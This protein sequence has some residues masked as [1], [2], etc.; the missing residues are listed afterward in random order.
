MHV[1]NPE[2]GKT[3]QTGAFQTNYHDMGAGGVCPLL[4]IHGSGPGVS[5][6]A[7]WRGNIPALSGNRRVIAPDMAGFGFTQRLHRAAYD[8]VAWCRQLLNLLTA[9]DIDQV[10]LVGNSFGGGIAL[11]FAIAHPAR[12][13]RLVLMGSV[14]VSFPITDGLDAV[15]GYEPSLGAMKGL[16]DIFAYDRVLVTDD[17]AELRYQASIQPGFQESFAALFPAPRQRWVEALASDE[18]DIAALPHRAL[19]IHGRDDRVIP[20]AT[21]Q[22]LHALLPDADLHIFARCGH[23]TQI[24][25]A[26]EF[27]ALVEGFLVAV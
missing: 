3:I 18:G 8:R 16:L 10:D 20:L 12:V 13:R 4:M 7:N 9:L 5:A 22:R 24:E 26:A 6:W 17:L 15:W 1:G 19:V 11:A 14:G 21:S 25:R 27:N 2:I 23:W